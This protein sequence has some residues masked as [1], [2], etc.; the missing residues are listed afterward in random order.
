ME[1]Q[2]HLLTALTG[3]LPS[4]E[5]AET[6]ELAALHLPARLPLSL[7]SRLVEQRPDIR[8]AQ[9]NLHSASAQIGV[10]VANRLPNITLTA[11][12]GSTALEMPSVTL[13][14]MFAYAPTLAAAGVPLSWP[15]LLLKVAHEG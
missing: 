12:A 14:R 9:S 7:P 4:E 6:F 1:Q 11:N 13:I 5:G 3:R 10:A 15:V 2:R 8:A